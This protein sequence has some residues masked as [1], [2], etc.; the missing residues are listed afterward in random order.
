MKSMEEQGIVTTFEEMAGVIARLGILPLAQLIPEHP[1][2]NGLTKAEN[3][4]T[5]SELDPWAWRARFPGE[6]LAGYGKFIR[7]KAI[8]VSREWFPAFA[9]AVGSV[10]EIEERYNNGLASREAVVLLQIIRDNEGIETRELRALA[11]MK[12]KEKKTAFDNA[13]TELQGTA[14]IVISGVKAR[15]N[16][17]GVVNG[18]NSTSF[19]TAGHWMQVNNLSSFEGSREEA[20]AWLQSAMTDVWTPAAI[21]WIRKVMSW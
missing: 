12:V 17:E 2:V 14:D 13:L 1:S 5:G 4:H 3:W 9:A 15:L 16:A 18:W 6:G 8:L 20:A 7:K 10:Q 21:A 11:D 19:E